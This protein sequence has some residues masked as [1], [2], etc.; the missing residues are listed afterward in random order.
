MNEIPPQHKQIRF[1]ILYFIIALIGIW[2]FQILVYQPLLIREQEV[3]YNTF[4]AEL[5]QGYIKEV[6]IGS[7]R[8]YFTIYATSDTAAP[9][10]LPTDIAGKSYNAVAVKDDQLVPDLLKAGVTFRAQPPSSGFLST[11]LGW[12]IPLALIAVIWYVLF[13]RMGRGGGNILSI[14]KSKAHMIAGEMTGIKFDD[15]GGMDEV[16]VELKEIIEFLKSPE[17]FTRLGA[18]LPKGVL[19]VGPPG[20]GKTLLA[21]ATAGEAEVPFF[22]LSGSDFVEMFVGVGAAR[23]RDLFEQAKVKAPCLVFIDE[24]DAIGQSRATIGAL[25]TNDER[26]Q[27]LNQL[28]SEMDG[29]EPNQGVV[30]MGATNRPEVLDRALLRPG[31]FDRQIQV[32]LPT[33]AGRLQILEIH[34]RAVPLEP[35]VDLQRLAQITPGFSGADLANIVNEAALLAVRRRSDFVSMTD[36][37]LAIERVVAGLQR[38][39]PLKE[40]VRRRVAYHEGGHALV[41]QVLLHTHPVHKVSIIPTAK[42]ALGYTMQMPEEDEY[43]IGSG[44]LQEQLAVMMGGRAAELLVF[45]EASTGAANDFERVT[46]MARRLV[47]EFGM[48]EALGPVRYV[49]NAGMGYLGAIPMLRQELSQETETLIDREIRRLVEEAQQT[50]L[51]LLKQHEAALH[52]IARILQEREVISGDEIKRIAEGTPQPEA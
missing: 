4:R 47:T 12:A 36:F 38:K 16:E 31:R 10:D 50:A 26:E 14:G 18:R 9:K 24:I 5:A 44:E 43:L 21:Q 37:D 11:L 42:G 28:L 27:T 19:L 22:S 52:E 39:L 8:I 6:T 46:D 3:S 25:Q 17:P 35:H 29:F 13:R 33:E 48:T 49:T 2:L 30:I 41:A 40:E 7:S 23:V 51:D 1:S 45:H 20:T 34:V 15:V 32:T